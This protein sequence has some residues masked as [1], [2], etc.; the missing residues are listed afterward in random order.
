MVAASFSAVMGTCSISR[1]RFRS[2]TRDR[3]VSSEGDYTPGPS[4][5]PPTEAT[6]NAQIPSQACSKG[7]GALLETRPRPILDH[8]LLLV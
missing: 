5:G 1:I 3:H 8:E 6:K 7:S 2:S 4:A